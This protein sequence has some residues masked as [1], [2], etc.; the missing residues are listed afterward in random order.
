MDGSYD[1]FG[2]P[3]SAQSNESVLIDAVPSVLPLYSPGD[4]VEVKEGGKKYRAAKIIKFDAEIGSL[5]VLYIDNGE[6]ENGAPTSLVRKQEG[7]STNK[8]LPPGISKAA[9]S[10][11]STIRSRK[12]DKARQCYDLI[13]TFSESEQEAAYSIL[14]SLDSV[15]RRS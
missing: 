12:S 4:E 6:K 8:N 15:R 3:I 5:D 2:N 13:K 11:Q 9:S 10:D 1:I 7:G 14:L